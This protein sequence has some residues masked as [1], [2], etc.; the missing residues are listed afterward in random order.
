[1]SRT[2][3]DVSV[4]VERVGVDVLATHLF[5][6]LDFAEYRAPGGTDRVVSLTKGMATAGVM[7]RIVA[8]LDND[9]AGRVA[10]DQLADLAF[11]PGSP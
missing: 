2:R 9:T 11:P 8:V 3:L 7:N 5:E 6:F 1:M 10:A 4:P